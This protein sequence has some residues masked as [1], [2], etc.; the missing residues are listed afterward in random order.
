MMQFLSGTRMTASAMTPVITTDRTYWPWEHKDCD[1]I[2]DP[3][4]AE[5]AAQKS[6]HVLPCMHLADDNE[7]NTWL[8]NGHTA[9]SMNLTLSGGDASMP[10]THTTTYVGEENTPQGP[11]GSDRPAPVWGHIGMPPQDGV[12]GTT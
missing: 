11:F 4:W 10:L 6:E 3:D 9:K 8:R 5:G 7:A 2:V 1:V 12:G